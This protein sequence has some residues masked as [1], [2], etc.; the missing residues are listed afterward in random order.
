[1]DLFKGAERREKGEK[2]KRKKK[3]SLREKNALKR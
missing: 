2:G 1:V 3:E